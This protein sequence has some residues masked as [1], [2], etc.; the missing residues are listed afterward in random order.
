MSN[1]FNKFT[2][3]NG[4]GQGGALSILFFA[5]FMDDFA[6]NI[7]LMI[8][9]VDYLKSVVVLLHALVPLN[10]IFSNTVVRAF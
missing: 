2:F 7:N 1:F 8:L 6:I 9:T 3:S 5:I 10:C 4:V